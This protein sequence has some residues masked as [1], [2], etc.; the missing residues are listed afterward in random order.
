MGI[1]R[2]LVSR[3]ASELANAGFHSLVIWVLKDNPAC[4]FYENLGGCVVAEK[5][6]EIGGKQLVDV[7]YIWRDLGALITPTGTPSIPQAKGV[8][9]HP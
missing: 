3:M 6:I 4:R 9:A 1:G 2:L 8:H 7:A 5:V